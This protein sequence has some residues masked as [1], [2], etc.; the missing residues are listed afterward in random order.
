[1]SCSFWRKI[2]LRLDI[3]DEYSGTIGVHS[4]AISFLAQNLF[5]INNDPISLPIRGVFLMNRQKGIIFSERRIAEW[6]DGLSE[7][8]PLCSAIRIM[9]DDNLGAILSMEQSWR[10]GEFSRLSDPTNTIT[11]VG[12]DFGAP[13]G[14]LRVAVHKR[15]FRKPIINWFIDQ[16]TGIPSR[17]SLGFV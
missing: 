16:G 14:D 1:M 8:E 5:S 11:V 10:S 6:P 2:S 17:F 9:N 3:P 4:F 7:E 15:W 12:E 13:S